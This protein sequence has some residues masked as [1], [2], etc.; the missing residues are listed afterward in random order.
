M[1]HHSSLHVRR[2]SISL[3]A[4]SLANGGSVGVVNDLERTNKAG[5]GTASSAAAPSSVLLCACDQLVGVLL[6]S[7]IMLTAYGWMDG[8]M[9]PFST[10]PA[11]SVSKDCSK[12][13]ILEC[14][15]AASSRSMIKEIER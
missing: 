13:D 11:S 6:H 10:V 7:G 8:W 1:I 14:H 12:S 4:P 9:L 3:A 15:S 2:H 5:I